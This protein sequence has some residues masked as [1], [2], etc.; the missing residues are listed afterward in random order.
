MELNV[1]I[2]EENLSKSRFSL[3]LP[4]LTTRARWRRWQKYKLSKTFP[5]NDTLITTSIYVWIY[6]CCFVVA[7]KGW[8]N[9]FCWHQHSRFLYAGIAG[10]SQRGGKRKLLCNPRKIH[11]EEEK[12]SGN[13]KCVIYHLVYITQNYRGFSLTRFLEFRSFGREE[14]EAYVMVQWNL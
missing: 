13:A 11:G 7:K 10:I 5:N 12:A 8:R 4:R 1:K 6:C 2:E 3:S 14:E 9:L